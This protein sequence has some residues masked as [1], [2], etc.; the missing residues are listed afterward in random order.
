M[1][2]VHCCCYYYYYYCCCCFVCI[3][4][5]Q[6]VVLQ[7]TVQII[8]LMNE[9]DT[10]LKTDEYKNALQQTPFEPHGIVKNIKPNNVIMK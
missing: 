6:Q 8:C 10:K 9:T 4:R 3:N 5:M 2:I 7:S 1:I